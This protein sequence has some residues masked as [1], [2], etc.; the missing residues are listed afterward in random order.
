MASRIGKMT[1]GMA[2]ACAFSA[3][4]ADPVPVEAFAR[5]GK[6][7]SPRLAPDGKHLSVTLNV[8]DG[9]HA[10]AIFRVEGMQP[11][12]VLKLPPNEVPMQVGWVS[13]QRLVVAKGRQ[14]GPREKP[15]PTGE[16]NAVDLDGDN[17]K[18]IFG[19]ESSGRTVGIDRGFGYIE[20][21]PEKANGRFYMRALSAS[22]NRSMLYD[23]DAT[24]GTSR[25]VADI[26]Q[27]DLSF[28]LDRSGRARFAIGT[29]DE[30]NY[31]LYES[32]PK[33]KWTP[34]PPDRTGGKLV[35]FAFSPDGTEVFAW[36]ASDG[37]P[38]SLV[39]TA[40]DGTGRQALVEDSFASV[41]DML[42]T[43]TPMHPFAAW[44]EGGIP[45]IIYF[46]D[47]VPEAKV[48]RVLGKS[49]AGKLVDF[50]DHSEDGRTSL[51]YVHSDRDPGA[52]YLFD[53]GRNA[54]QIVFT[55]MEAIQP[56]RMGVRRPVRFKASDG[57]ELD[58]F[59]TIPAGT[60]EPSKLPM[61]LV[62]H[63]GPHAVGDRWP[64]DT[65]AQFLASRGY[66]VLQVNYR[67]SQGRGK[68]FEQAG[69]RHWATRIQDDLLDGVRW[70]IGQGY[71]DP[72]RVCA[73]GASFG[74]YSAMMSAAR[75]PELF[76][77]AVGF[78]GIYDLGMM[79]DKGDIRQSAWGRNYLER[80][81]GTD[82][83]E[84]EAGSPTSLAARIRAPVLL[85]HGET[86]R[87]APFAQAKA[88]RKAL[89]KADHPPEWMAVPKEGHGFY[90][91]E[92]NIAFYQRLESFIGKHIGSAKP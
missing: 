52:W 50:V 14:T 29:D 90:K 2:A 43:A 31:L 27:R 68:T 66:L 5:T 53:H 81:I 79:Y 34:I 22:S 58:G 7:S 56:D 65:D 73:Y 59:L 54:A 16:I 48:H 35:P 57:L 88:M 30:D 25:L 21:L 72:Q 19:Y 45:A 10:L 67:G 46:D 9:R 4:A 1:I 83:A 92:N 78:A 15:M 60:G 62:P 37:G 39:R 51:L 47:D 3:A 84:L 26:G 18:Y 85:V 24:D 70:A 86:D 11:T 77:C 91:D 64:F 69:Y 80:A 8:G 49:F 63:G 20:G 17:Q 32:D 55:A 40:P 6:I 13:P 75:A 38:M 28:V 87:R 12:L 89:E 36:F 42:W 61:V 74:A 23:V 44:K 82:E 76:K 71:A 33:D 41:G